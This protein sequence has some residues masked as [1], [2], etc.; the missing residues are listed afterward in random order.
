MIDRDRTTIRI[1]NAKSFACR[2]AEH[3]FAA[4]NCTFPHEAA[5]LRATAQEA[6]AQSQQ[7]CDKI[8]KDAEVKPLPVSV[9][10]DRLVKKLRAGESLYENNRTPLPRR[11]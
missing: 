6:Q 10:I 1:H 8:W 7:L 9:E 2:A 11:I 5:K 4:D 3:Y